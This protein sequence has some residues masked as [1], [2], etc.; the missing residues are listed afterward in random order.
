MI[1]KLYANGANAAQ[2]QAWAAKNGINLNVPTVAPAAEETSKG[3]F[4]GL[5]GLRDKFGKGKSLLS[6]KFTLPNLGKLA[7]DV[8]QTKLIEGGPTIGGA[9]NTISG[10]YQG[11]KALSGLY[12]NSNK[13]SD[14]SSLKKD[15]NL[16][17]ASN[18]MYDMNL[19]AADEKILRQMQNG[20]LTNN[21]AGAAEGAMKGIP[22]AAL[23]AIMG[24]LTGGPLGAVIGGAG[25]LLNSGISGYGQETDEANAQLQGLYSKLRASEDEYNSMKRPRGL[26]GAGLSSRY[27]NQLY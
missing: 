14:L 23:S 12:E 2:I 9:A 8:R 26:R 20:T 17:M 15:I 18:P 5:F 25:S 1:E 16:S 22:Q 11:G 7:S 10:I 21:W 6:G 3:L 19:T 4:A 13:D 27:Y 24:G